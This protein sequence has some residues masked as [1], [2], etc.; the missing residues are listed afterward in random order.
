MPAG[1][2]IL[3]TGSFRSGS[4]WAG[5]MVAAS[6]KVVYIQEPLNEHYF[7]PGI[8][9]YYFDEPFQYITKESD[10]EISAQLQRTVDLKYDF[11]AG[12]R[13]AKKGYQYAWAVINQFN[14]TLGRVQGRRALFKDPFAIFSAPWLA[15]EFD[16]DVVVLIRHPA[17]FVSSVKRMQ[18]ESPVQLLRQ[19]ERLMDDYLN[20]LC[21]E[22]DVFLS[23]PRTIVEQAAFFWKAA[24]HSVYMYQQQFPE[25]HYTRHEDLSRDPITGFQQI[26]GYLSLPY[27]QSIQNKINKY[28]NPENPIE[29]PKNETI[30]QLNSNEN[31][32]N[33]K[34]RLTAEEI[35]Q[36]KTLSSGVWEHF[37][38]EEDW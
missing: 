11:P 1:K 33:W 19:Q 5:R 21:F 38:T 7:D 24:Y 25:W 4:T 3:I 16:M 6:P 28:S 8:C 22:M 31:T 27:T 10:P 26:F 2:P 32:Q 35:K 20:P 12:F 23:Q 13:H 18:W 15:E 29:A 36:V 37:Y 30:Y 34:H 17:A 14:Y 9:S